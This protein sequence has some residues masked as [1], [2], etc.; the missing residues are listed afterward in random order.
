M[1]ERNLTSRLVAQIQPLTGKG[2]RGIAAKKKLGIACPVCGGELE[3]T[4]FGYG[5]GN[6]KK[7]GTGCKFSIGTIAGRD[8]SEE[9]FRDL[10]TKEERMFWMVLS[11]N[12]RRNSRQH[13]FYRRMRREKSIS[14][15]IFR[16]MNHRWWKESNA[17][18]AAVTL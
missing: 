18:P 14:V 13:S 8:L 17:R 9:E 7:D 1:V 10:I 15:L 2:A 12:R 4:P 5:C 6:Y 3:T 11:P 16:Q